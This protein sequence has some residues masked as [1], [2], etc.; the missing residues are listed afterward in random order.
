MDVGSFALGAILV[1]LCIAP[2]VA[3]HYHKR[4][5]NSALLDVIKEEAASRHCQISRFEFCGDFVLGVDD[6]KNTLFFHK[7]TKDETVTEFVDLHHIKSCKPE[8]KVRSINA[9]NQRSQIIE[10]LDLV[11]IPK[12]GDD[13][14]VRFELYDES[15]GG[16]LSGELQFLEEWAV[17]IQ[18]RLAQLK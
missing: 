15:T 2:F 3:I 5:L 11:F 7:D 4:K 10:R 6:E 17:K 16:Q 9:N 1:A 12:N 18:D 8:K 14:I 13:P